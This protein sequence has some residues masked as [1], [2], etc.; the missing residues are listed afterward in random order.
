MKA[1]KA[2]VVDNTCSINFSWEKPTQ[3]GGRPI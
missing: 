3:D 1:V 2:I